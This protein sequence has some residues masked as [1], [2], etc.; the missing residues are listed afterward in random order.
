MTHKIKPHWKFIERANL[1]TLQKEV[2]DFS[3]KNEVQEV[4]LASRQGGTGV[5][6]V[7]SI[8]H[9]VDITDLEIKRMM[10]KNTGFLEYL[11]APDRCAA[12]KKSEYKH[13]YEQCERELLGIPA[14]F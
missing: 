6:Y 5:I 4:L 9:L 1:E 3:D 10:A 13:L 2:N 12:E 14:P 8:R 11:K 7:A